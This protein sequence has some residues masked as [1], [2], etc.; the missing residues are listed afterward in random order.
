[1]SASGMRKSLTNTSCALRGSGCAGGRLSAAG[2]PACTR[3]AIFVRLARL[4][5]GLRPE[6]SRA[7]CSPPRISRSEEH[8]SELQSLMRTSYAVF[9]LK[10]KTKKHKHEQKLHMTY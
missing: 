10:T 2:W 5:E 7:T 8:T 9:C 6:P 3:V 1:M 4:A